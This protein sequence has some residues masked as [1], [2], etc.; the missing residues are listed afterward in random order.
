MSSQPGKPGIAPLIASDD[1]MPP[2]AVV[3]DDALLDDEEPELY[4]G[5]TQSP[6]PDDA[7][8]DASGAPFILDGS[9]L[10]GVTASD[11]Y[12]SV[13]NHQALFDELSRS[14]SR[15]RDEFAKDHNHGA[16]AKLSGAEELKS[17]IEAMLAQ[18]NQGRVRKTQL[19]EGLVPALAIVVAAANTYPGLKEMLLDAI[20]ALERLLKALGVTQ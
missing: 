17:E 3:F 12:A 18:T 16:Y 15:I 4:E 9:V 10:T 5:F 1:E 19:T 8:R 6:P 7:V 11:R 14:L 20:H 2:R 13:R